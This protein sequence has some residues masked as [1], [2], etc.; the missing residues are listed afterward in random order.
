MGNAPTIAATA[1]SPGIDLPELEVVLG[2]G[3]PAAYAYVVGRQLTDLEATI[4][5]D[6]SKLS[7]LCADLAEG[8]CRGDVIGNAGLPLWI[9]LP[10]GMPGKACRQLTEPALWAGKIG[11][12]AMLAVEVAL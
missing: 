2:V 10:K 5:M 9:S 1:L 11:F 12:T 3:N 4:G 8:G 7:A 6:Q